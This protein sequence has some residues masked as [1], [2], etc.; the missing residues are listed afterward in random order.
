ML[1]WRKPA[2]LPT[3]AHVRMDAHCVLTVLLPTCCL[4]GTAQAKAD[5]TLQ[6]GDQY[7]GHANPPSPLSSLCRWRQPPSHPPRPRLSTSLPPQLLPAHLYPVPPSTPRPSWR[8]TSELCTGRRHF[9]C[10]YS[11]QPASGPAQLWVRMQAKGWAQQRWRPIAIL[12][13]PPS[14]ST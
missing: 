3:V 1:I 8:L 10:V 13:R 4:Q 12:S 5:L 14:L 7:L 2:F 6:P 9:S 11:P